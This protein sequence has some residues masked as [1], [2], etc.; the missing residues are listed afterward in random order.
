MQDKKK[1]IGDVILN[2][3]QDLIY[4]YKKFENREIVI[5]SLKQNFEN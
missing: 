5:N 4:G 3:I 1:C 2:C